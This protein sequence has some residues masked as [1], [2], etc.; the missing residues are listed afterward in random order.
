MDF[1]Q[2][3]RDRLVSAEAAAKIV[4]SGDR[5]DFGWT[6]TTPVAFDIAM[7]KRL[8]NFY[9]VNFRGA[10]LMWMPEIFKIENP[11]EHMTWN[12]WHMGE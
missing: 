7:A 6:A 11:S 3:Y 4:R 2:V 10:I 12:S 1:Q 5:V 9:D 8:N